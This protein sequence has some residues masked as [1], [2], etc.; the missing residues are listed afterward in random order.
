MANISIKICGLK[1]KEAIKTAQDADFI[2]FIFFAKSPRNIEAELALELKQYV[3]NSK[4]VAVTVNPS[5]EF[6]ENILRLKPDYLQLHGEESPERVREIQKQFATPIIKAFSIKSDKDFENVEKYSDLVDF[7]L[8]DAKVDSELP[9]G[10][11]KSFDW[12]LLKNRKF[13]KKWFLSGGINLSNVEDALAK[14]GAD[15]IDVS[16]GV[17]SEIGVKSP[18]MIEKFLRKARDVNDV[19]K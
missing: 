18:E 2:G 9:G 6:L 13:S 3:K 7:C 15:M 8:F 14:T 16:S 11:G 10:N 12:N 4:I 19:K 5:N 17:E 1:N